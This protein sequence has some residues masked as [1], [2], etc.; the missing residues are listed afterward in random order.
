M[1]IRS[2][3]FVL[4]FTGCQ[5]G[6]YFAT[7][8]AIEPTGPLVDLLTKEV[9]VTLEKN[10]PPARSRILFAHDKEKL[11]A[12]LEGALRKGGYAL[13]SKDQAAKEG[14]L[15]LGYTLDSIDSR[16]IILRMVVGENFASSRLYAKREDGSYAPA[17][18]LLIRRGGES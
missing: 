13:I 6:G 3:V 7:Q 15:R 12:A 14:D 17:G 4:I 9:L 8:E 1:G 5:T 2:L 10:F 16:T 11:A 18:P